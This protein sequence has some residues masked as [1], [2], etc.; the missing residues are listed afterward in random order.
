MRKGWEMKKIEPDSHLIKHMTFTLP[1]RLA[2]L[3]PEHLSYVYLNSS[4]P[5]E[6]YGDWEVD[7][8]LDPESNL[9]ELLQYVSGVPQATQLYVDDQNGVYGDSRRMDETEDLYKVTNLGSFEAFDS[10]MHCQSWRSC[11]AICDASQ[12][13]LYLFCG[14][15][16][17]TAWILIPLRSERAIPD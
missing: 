4:V 5:Q 17:I 7:Q 10:I 15:F 12:Q 1:L 2:R 13:E 16:D 3:V 6:L 8:Y 14:V 9:E 11:G